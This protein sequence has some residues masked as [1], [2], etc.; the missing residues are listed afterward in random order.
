MDFPGFPAGFNARPAE[1]PSEPDSTGSPTYVAREIA[2]GRAGRGGR[3]GGGGGRGGRAETASTG[4]YRVVLD[5]DGQ[6][7]AAVLRVVK[8]EPGQ[9]T[10]MA[11]MQR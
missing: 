7:S 11:P 4:D 6:K 8:V 2:A 9:R 3:G 5:M 1:P 10:V